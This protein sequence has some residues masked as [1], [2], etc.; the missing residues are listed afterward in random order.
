MPDNDGL[1]D[2]IDVAKSLAAALNARGKD[3]ALGGALALGYWAT[4]RGTLDVDL[5]LFIPKERPTECVLLLQEL[6]CEVS[7]AAAVVSL[8]SHGFCR[9]RLQDIPV[10]VFVPSIPFYELAKARRRQ[11]ALEEQSVWIWDAESL[12][13][14]KMMF[15]REKDLLDLKQ[16]LGRQKSAFDRIWVRDQLVELFGKRD[17]RVAEWDRML[18]DVPAT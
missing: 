15:F 5:T 18:A 11:M 7:A 10:D 6:G 14:F 1:I 17:P 8:Q 4:P 2:P 13:V 12:A 16:V 9:V 3:Y